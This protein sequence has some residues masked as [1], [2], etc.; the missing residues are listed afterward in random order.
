MPSARSMTIGLIRA[1]ALQEK[2]VYSR[3]R[4]RISSVLSRSAVTVMQ[5]PPRHDYTTGLQPPKRRRCERAC[6]GADT[7]R[8]VRNPGTLR[9]SL[10]AA[11]L[12]IVGMLAAPA[13][14][15]AE[16]GITVDEL[17]IK[18]ESGYDMGCYA[19][20]LGWSC[21]AWPLTVTIRPESGEASFLET[22][23]DE[24]SYYGMDSSGRALMNDF[25]AA[26]CRDEAG[27][28]AFV[29]EVAALTAQGQ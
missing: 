16:G 26:A 22:R 1:C 8:T 13:G 18:A 12:A 2:K 24:D 6:S 27:V 15:L 19:D 29:D 4:R 28:A 3:F 9:A 11:T 17:R 5:E 14:M 7:V 21:S 25:H 23:S 20:G 10:A